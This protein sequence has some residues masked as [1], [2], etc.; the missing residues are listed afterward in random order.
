MRLYKG[1]RPEAQGGKFTNKIRFFRPLPADPVH[2]AVPQPV[3]RA[4]GG[5]AVLR[6]PLVARRVGVGAQLAAASASRVGEL[7][8]LLVESCLH[9]SPYSSHSRLNSPLKSCLI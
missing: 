6:A 9:G 2:H 3:R 1:L 5:G 8:A 7:I 4:P